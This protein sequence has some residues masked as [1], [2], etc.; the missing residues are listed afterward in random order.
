MLRYKLLA[1]LCAAAVCASLAGCSEGDGSSDQ[2]SSGASSQSSSADTKAPDSSVEVKPAKYDESVGTASFDRESGF[3][4]SEFDLTL[5]AGEGLTI[6]YTTDG[7]D[8]TMESNLYSGPIHIVNRSHEPDVLAAI[9]STTIN[10]DHV[11]DFPVK[12]GTVIKAAAFKSDGS[13]G[14]IACGTFFVGIDR[15]K[16][17]KDVPIVSI[18]TD[19]D[20]LFGYE[21]GIYVRGKV[22]DDWIAED[23]ANAK[24]NAWEQKAN[25]TV[26]GREAERPVTVSLIEADGTVGFT[27]NFGVRIS[28]AASRTVAQKSLRFTA[29]EEYGKKNL[30]YDLIPGNTRSDGTGEVEKYKSFVL[31][32]GGN[33]CSFAKMRDPLLQTLISGADVETMQGRP[34]V[35]FINGEYWGMYYLCEDYSDNYF[36]N[37]YPIEKE[38]VVII[39]VGQVE[40]GTE[41]D[42][43]LYEE[44]VDYINNN[45]MSVEA[46][47]KKA[48]EMLDMQSYADYMAFNIYI[49]NQDSILEKNNWRMWRVRTP[50]DSCEQADG[51]WRM[52]VYDTDY[53]TGVYDGGTSFN[54]STLAGAVSGKKYADNPAALMLSSLCSNESFKQMFT[55]SLLD[56]RNV[57]FEKKTVKAATEELGEY[58]SALAPATYSRF[59][60]DWISDRKYID[61]KIDELKNFLNGRNDSFAGIVEKAMDLGEKHKLVLNTGEGQVRLNAALVSEGKE[62][63]CYY[64]EECPV[65]LTAVAPEGKKFVRWEGEDITIPDSTAETVTLSITGDCTVTAVFE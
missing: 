65:T 39:K 23:P 14:D 29:R 32:N 22:Y 6:Y 19:Q 43:A 10:E 36:E 53:S 33:D 58:Y 54:N 35:A 27:Q 51:R 11:P 55:N 45:D 57:Y 34:C 2:N 40:E 24:K 9:S 13:H 61:Y 38:N 41:E 64:L 3:Y 60:P 47:Y 16:Q 59:G 21:N 46:N 25:F 28:G 49:A 26:R 44:L 62:L 30:K 50:G 8:P 18:V 20:N 4:E 1:A 52:A 17:Y 31:R 48:S 5:T 63:Y 12:K 7:S 15:E 37:N 42:L 56:M